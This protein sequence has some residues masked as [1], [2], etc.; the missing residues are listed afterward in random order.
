M[1]RTLVPRQLQYKMNPCV[2][3]LLIYILSK[4]DLAKKTNHAMTWGCDISFIDHKMRQDTC[5]D[6]KKIWYMECTC[7]KGGGPR[8]RF[9]PQTHIRSFKH[10]TVHNNDVRINTIGVR[11]LLMVTF[12]L[13]IRFCM[14]QIDEFYILCWMGGPIPSHRR[15]PPCPAGPRWRVRWRGPNRRV[16]KEPKGA[17]PSLHRVHPSHVALTWT[18]VNIVGGRI[19]RLHPW[20]LAVRARNSIR[21]E[22]SWRELFSHK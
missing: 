21:Q 22:H 18:H 2:T 4:V 12:T 6:S 1:C 20:L 5:K 19:T 14:R 16:R 3:Y 8:S 17:P 15:F 9:R 10:L 7:G 11:P 13:L